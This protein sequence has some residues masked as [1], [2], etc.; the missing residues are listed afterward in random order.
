MSECP[1]CKQR[2]GLLYL[3]QNCPHCG[4]NLCFYNFEENFY[5]D[6]KRAELSLAKINMFIAHMKASYIGSKLTIARLCVMLLPILSFLVPYGKAMFSQPFLHGGFSLSALGLYGVYEDGYLPYLLSMTGS[7]VTGKAFLLL[8]SAIAAYLLCAVAA[9]LI[10][11]MTLLCF[12]N[13]KKMHRILAGVAI[14]GAALS[15]ISF[16]LI[17]VFASYAESFEMLSGKTFPGFL[18]SVLCFAA[19][20]AINFLIGRKGLDIVYREGDEQR[21]AIA[22]KV[23][24]GEIKL[25][26][27]PQP[28]VETAETEK[29]QA[30]YRKLEEGDGTA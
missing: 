3:K 18:V 30:L 21:A 10:F 12:L 8:D 29:Q 6:A 1:N 19:V 7:D 23:K 15:V 28:V 9:L 26:D 14:A 17:A 27:L 22:K 13:V 16:V 11:F 2:I 20:A 5:R 4:V 25:E 24:A